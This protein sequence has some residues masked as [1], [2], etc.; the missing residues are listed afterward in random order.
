MDKVTIADNLFLQYGKSAFLGQDNARL[1][2]THFEWE[3]SD[4]RSARFVTDSFIQ[5]AC[6]KGQVAWLLEPFL[7]HPENYYAAVQKG[8][9]HVLTCNRYFASNFGWLWY[10]HGGSWIDFNAWKVYRKTK[11]VSIVL[12]DKNSMPGHKLRH[13]IVDRLAERF[14]DIF[15]LREK[16]RMLDGLAPYRFSVIVENE[17]APGYFTEKLID[18]LS[19]GTIPIY[20]GCPDTDCYFDTRGILHIGNAG[21]VEYFLDRLNENYYNACLPAIR[22]NLEYAKIYRIV[23]DRIFEKYPFLFE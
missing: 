19:V 22:S 7:M 21:E 16:V 6:G 17:R 15:G 13:E 10:P 11:N 9:D 14:D 12:S 8:F 20:W 1:A 5:G 23:E 3:L 4:A 18:C 2:P